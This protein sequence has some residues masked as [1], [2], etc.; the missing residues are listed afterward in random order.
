M[1]SILLLSSILLISLGFPHSSSAQEE[2][3]RLIIGVHQYPSTFHPS[4]DAI[5]V[6]QY[7]LALVHRPFMVYDA[8][9]Q[10]VCLLCTEKPRRD[11][12]T[13]QDY[14]QDD[15]TPS[16]KVTYTIRPDAR[17]GDN[18]PITTKD[19]L[20]AWEVG[21]HPASGFAASEV[22][23]RDIVD[24]TVID[25]HTFTLHLFQRQCKPERI[26][27]AFD[28]LPEHLERPIFEESPQDYKYRTLYQTAPTTPGL[29]FGPYRITEVQTGSAIV[30]ERNPYWWGKT[31]F[32]S[33]VVIRA[34]EDSFALESALLAGDID[35]IAGEVGLSFD[36][37]LALHENLQNQD[38]ERFEVT[39]KPGL[40][41]EH[42]EI[43]HDH[44]ILSDLRVRQ[45][46]LLGIDRQAISDVLF[47]GRQPVADNM[48]STL[49][50]N[51]RVG[52]DTYSFDPSMARRLLDEAG[53]HQISD[54][55]RQKDGQRL[56]LTLATTAGNRSRE[57][58]QQIL[59]AMWRDIGIGVRIKNH[60]P[61]IL[62][63]D[64]LPKRNFEIAMFAWISAPDD[65]PR[66]VLHSTRI[67]QPTNEYTG[68]NFTGFR[69]PEL[70]VVL[71]GLEIACEE[72]IN[73]ALWTRLQEIY[74]QRLPAL[75]LFYR[76]DVYIKPLWL[77]G[78]V[79]TGHQFASTLWIEEWY[80][81][82]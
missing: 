15:G 56:Q 22:Y 74:A 7:V 24:I 30:V 32:F 11:N 14:I 43:N 20:F 18:T 82:D 3:E 76:T 9:W 71:D 79:P 77:Q 10:L 61:R 72:K 17:W 19:V 62:F 69:D 29:Y 26:I 37:A 46:L 67:P 54:G 51:H 59:Q 75:P 21:K 49:D 39:Y 25:E 50:P 40:F 60:I 68:Q 44:E 78:I 4:I 33:S 55:I 35:Y 1:S 45:A 28:I 23:N 2:Q 53:W 64:L 73:D 13:I 34:I 41:Y 57:R 36:R 48:I 16:T 42:L 80:R 5:L 6:N 58:V 52:Y 31:P 8:D 27:G 81:R 47:R 12:H 65:I 63:G 38:P 70:D 66:S